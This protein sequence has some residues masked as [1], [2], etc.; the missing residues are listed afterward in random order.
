MAYGTV[1]VNFVTYDVGSGDQ[2]INV[3]DVANA[4][5][6]GFTVTGAIG[7]QLLTS[8]SGNIDS[9]SGGF[10]SYTSGIVSTLHTTSGLFASGTASNPSISF[11]NDVDTGFYTPSGN[12]LGG[13]TQGVERFRV[14]ESGISINTQTSTALLTVNDNTAGTVARFTQSGAGDALVISGSTR[15]SGNVS[16]NGNT[17]ITGSISISG[18]TTLNAQSEI[19]FADSDS[20]NYVGF[21]SPGTVASNVIWTLPSGDGTL[22]QVLITDGSGVTSWGNIYTEPSDGDKGDIIV[23]SSGLNWDIDNEVISN[24]HISPTAA[25][26][27]TKLD[28]INSAN[29]VAITAI[30]IDGG[31]DIGAAIADNDLFVIDDGATGTNRKSDASRIPTYVFAKVSG[32]LTVNSS[33]VATVGSGIS[34]VKIIPDFGTQSISTT[35]SGT[36]TIGG[37]ASG[38]VNIYNTR[39][40]TGISGLG[41]GNY[42][43]CSIGLNV[44]T[45]YVNSAEAVTNGSTLCDNIIHYNAGQEHLDLTTNIT[46][47][48]GFV[49]DGTLVGASNNY[50]FYSA[51]P[52]FSSLGS[53]W[54]FYAETNAP[55]YF[56]GDVRTNKT[57]VKNA[58]PVNSNTSTTATAASLIQGLRTGAPGSSGIVLQLPAGANIEAEFLGLEVGDSFEWSLIN[59]AT[60]NFSITVTIN[61]NHSVFGNMVVNQNISARFLTRKVSLNNFTTY[62]IA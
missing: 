28:V 52:V 23:S 16:I 7:A 58:T 37:V 61:S 11:T 45:V 47:Q 35:G 10:L 6:S 57:F 43:R 12:I 36:L 14:S 31:T 9:I 24:V 20:S 5:S 41:Y 26:I 54:N 38:N 2:T 60:F 29:K 59:T 19:R 1:K 13:V 50:G 62:R 40:I 8:N 30:D 22:G 33:G 42:T 21:K 44:S 25:I 34:G 3:E 55:N 56:E 53:G 18:N 15:H 39:T 46:N 17:T 32:E 27:D 4:L 51:V 48:Y 49:A